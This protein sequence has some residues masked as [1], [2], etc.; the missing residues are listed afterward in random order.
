MIIFAPDRILLTISAL[1]LRPEALGFDVVCAR[2]Y[3]IGVAPLECSSGFTG[4]DVCS[5]GNYNMQTWVTLT[6]ATKWAF[7]LDG[8]ITRACGCFR[9]SSFV[10]VGGSL[11]QRHASS[12]HDRK[13]DR[14]PERE[15]LR[16]LLREQR[17]R[18]SRS[19][20]CSAQRWVCPSTPH[21][22]SSIS[23]TYVRIVRV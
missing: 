18:Y 15:R 22:S 23:Q 3:V 10:N 12:Q 11:T 21:A 17:R 20:V 13:H 8:F 4:D 5:S 7:R 16:V 19:R 1:E 14:D 6:G 9:V 2:G